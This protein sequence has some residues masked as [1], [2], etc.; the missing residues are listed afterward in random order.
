[1]QVNEQGQTA[2]L[3]P[4]AVAV[5][6]WEAH[7]SQFLLIEWCGERSKVMS[8]CF[9][10]A[11]YIGGNRFIEEYD[12]RSRRDLQQLDPSLCSIHAGGDESEEA[13]VGLK[14]SRSFNCTFCRWFNREF[15]IPLT[16]DHLDV[17]RHRS[18][19]FRD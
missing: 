16:H 7:G 4:N 11:Q 8:A 19:V 1:M 15:A 13:N 3:R 9:E 12:L 5:S 17:K 10:V 14:R 18:L 2:G 6:P